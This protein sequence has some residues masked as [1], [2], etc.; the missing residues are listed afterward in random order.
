M[1]RFACGSVVPGCT[2]EFEGDDEDAILR[3]VAEH[4][5]RDHGMAEVP[6]EVVEQVR[7]NIEG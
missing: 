5:E 3:Q 1:K 6:A 4:A 7:V 2:A